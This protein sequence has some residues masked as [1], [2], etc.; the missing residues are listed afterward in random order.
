MNLV[1]RLPR[2]NDAA[3]IEHDR[4]LTF[5][6]LHEAMERMADA[7]YRDGLREGNTTLIL[8]PMSIDLYVTLLA[9]WRLGAVAMFLDPSAGLRH[10]ADCCA[11]RPPHALLGTRRAMWLRCVSPSL[12]RI[13]I[14]RPIT[15]RKHA[16]RSPRQPDPSTGNETPA[17]LTFTSGSTGRPKAAMR[18]H[19]FLLSQHNALASAL[20]L[21][22]GD[23]DLP[24]LPVFV[25]ANLA[26]GVTS[27]I[28]EADLRRPGFIDPAPVIAQIERYHPVSTTASPALLDRLADTALSGGK[29][30]TSFRKIFTGGAP[31][32]PSLLEKLARVAPHAAVVSVYG[33]TE[34]EPMAHATWEEI[35]GARGRGLLAGR[36]VPE[37]DLRVVTDR[38]GQPRT[39]AAALPA[40]VPGEIVVAGDHVLPG[41][42]DGVGDAETKFDAGGKRWHR[43]GDAGLIDDQGRLWLLGRCAVRI[44][45]T[46]GTIYPFEVE[47][48]ARPWRSAL[49][50][51]RGQRTLVVE[52]ADAVEELRQRLGWARIELFR[53]VHKIPMDNR[54]NAKVDYVALKR[55]LG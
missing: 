54:H 32:F 29:Q 36:P 18:S 12:R 4:Q 34:A 14:R 33:S 8:Q 13:P 46:H 47:C 26:S 49:V 50:S 19:G 28:P 22:A 52:E 2:T 55:L 9:V 45:D 30:L 10:V 15:M 16:T 20:Q 51:H 23:V 38:W 42:V 21:H 17:L 3:L 6:E 25:L 35:R 11:L 1:N 5:A 48:V 43:T 7:L 40:G 31:V 24:T 41:Y 27:I 39:D 37:V 53:V 44:S